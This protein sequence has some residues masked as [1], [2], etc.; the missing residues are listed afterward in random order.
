MSENIS[1][2]IYNF[3]VLYQL[4][5]KGKHRYWKTYVKYIN[6]NSSIIYKEYGTVDG[7]PIINEKEITVCRSQKTIFEQAKFEAQSDFNKKCT[8]DGYKELSNPIHSSSIS[9]ISSPS[10][11]SPQ[12]IN[13]MIDPDDLDNYDN[14]NDI[15]SVHSPE[16]ISKNIS[17]EQQITREFSCML[18]ETYKPHMTIRFP[19]FCQPKLD[20]VRMNAHYDNSK[21][22]LELFSRNNKSLNHISHIYTDLCKLYKY[23]Y[24]ENIIKDPYF[25]LDGE[26]YSDSIPFKKVAG[27]INRSVSFEKIPPNDLEKIQYHIYDCY[28]P[29]NPNMTF[30]ER[31]NML[32]DISE[33]SMGLKS[34]K[35]VKTKEI[36][37]KDDILKTH[38]EYIE[39]GYEGLMIRN[40]SGIYKIKGRSKDLLKYK[41]FSDSEFLIVGGKSGEGQYK[42]CL[43]LSL[44]T[45]SGN[46]FNC[47]V[48]G[49]IDE[50]REAYI[51]F[52]NDQNTFLNKMYTV[53]YQEIDDKTGVPRFP[54]GIGIRDE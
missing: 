46:I 32:D 43:I 2:N 37:Y 5:A 16:K 47:N 50:K 25:I 7:K 20:G 10:I 12:K 48:E 23:L 28:I 9:S 6:D 52:T 53:K 51:L 22:S 24:D 40:K 54:V 15:K 26:V 31:N 45:N 14:I 30:E 18:A 33:N 34:I 41:T 19:V 27:Y 3:P 1:D 49:T 13:K 38:S 17:L 36:Y 44:Q 35:F 21:K 8:K 39:K 29:S 4:D 11:P 42:G